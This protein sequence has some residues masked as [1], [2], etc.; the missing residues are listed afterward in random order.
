[1][2]KGVGFKNK[3]KDATKKVKETLKKV[4]HH[5]RTFVL[6]IPESSSDK[7]KD[8]VKLSALKT[9][10]FIAPENLKQLPGF[11]KDKDKEQI[12]SDLAKS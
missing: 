2:E 8:K 1:M 3:S 4:I 5:F 9:I 10:P 7:E 11:N 6:I 12:N